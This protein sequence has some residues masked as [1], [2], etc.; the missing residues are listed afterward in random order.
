MYD[1]LH[2]LIFFFN[3]VQSWAKKKEKN[4]NPK[5]VFARSK[6][7]QTVRDEFYYEDQC[8]EGRH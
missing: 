1:S 4:H 2:T 8:F 5:F 6:Y 7:L 3:E